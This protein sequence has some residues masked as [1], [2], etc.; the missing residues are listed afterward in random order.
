[1]ISSETGGTELNCVTD[2]EQTHDEMLKIIFG[3]WD[4]IKNYSDRKKEAENYYLDWVS[5]LPAKR[6]SRRIKSDYVLNEND[7]LGN[8]MFDDAV[9]YGGWHIDSHRPEGFYAFINKTPQREDKTVMFDG[10]YTIPYRSIYSKDIE[11]LF[12]GGRIISAS[13]RA[14]SSTR[15]MATCAAAARAAGIAAAMAV[16]KG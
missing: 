3:I 15:V 13:H 9:A 7:I 10:I 1:M 5:F 12:L 6:E 2:A 16:K 11:N 14:F 4:Y 8:R